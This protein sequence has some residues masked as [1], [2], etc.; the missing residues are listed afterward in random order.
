MKKGWIRHQKK[1]V[2]KSKQK[3]LDIHIRKN[4]K[5]KMQAQK[6]SWGIGGDSRDFDMTELFE[7]MG[8]QSDAAQRRRE[9]K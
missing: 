1:R 4:R 6:P 3:D 9:E 2:L 5:R 7:S 8:E